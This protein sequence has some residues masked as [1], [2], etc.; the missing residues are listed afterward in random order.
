[1]KF[2]V[3]IIGG[4]LSGLTAGIALAEA[5][6]DVALVS[7][8]QSTLH[9]TG[10]SIDLLGYD[11]QGNILT[12]PIKDN[13]VFNSKH[14]YEKIEDVSSLAG[15]AKQIL[16]RAGIAT[17]G[18]TTANHWRITPIGGLMPTWLSMDGMATI[19][20][21]EQMPWRKVAL[22]NIVNYLDFPT[23][24]IAAGLR[25]R[26]VEVDVKAV[27]LPEL[28]ELRKSP[29][30]MRSTN[31]AKVIEN[32]N[33][34]VKLADEVNAVTGNSYDMVLLPA[35]VGLNSSEK[36][37]QLLKL[38]NIP[39]GYVATLPPS[40]PGV[41]MQTLLRKRFN[42]LG[43]SFFTG[44]HVTQGIFDSDRM[45]GVKTAKLDG[46]TLEA[47]NFILATGSFVS[48]GLTADYNH[49]YETALGVD[50]DDLGLNRKTWAKIDVTQAQPYMEMGV[51][52]DDKLHCLRHGKAVS[53]LYAT[54]TILSGHNSVKSLDAGGIDMLTA[55]QAAK[56]ILK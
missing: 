10:G 20:N 35:I 6:K 21:P 56:N 33:L 22:V 37:Q 36:S 15:V 41:R 43:G 27:T 9:F 42:N 49:V 11:G 7:A 23:K 54:G 19:E 48:R 1:M 39:A 44:D 17:T 45:T 34:I 32:R 52:T 55:L 24:F 26:G 51:K 40:V 50:V 2:D 16:E 53:N 13:T 5:G 28:Q 12:D 18:Y 29:T 31:I 25:D 38:I 47:D 30:E 14:P 46:T 4:G 3:I 8:G